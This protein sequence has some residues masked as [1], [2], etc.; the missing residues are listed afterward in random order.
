MAFEI[1]SRV[2]DYAILAKLGAGGAGFVFKAR[3]VVTGRVEALKVLQSDGDESRDMSERF[4]REIRVQASLD[5]PNIAAVYSAFRASGRLV[6]AMEFVEGR[7]LREIADLGPVDMG[8]YMDYTRQALNALEYAHAREVIHRDIKPENILITAKGQVKLTDF[9]LAKI[10]KGESHT[11]SAALM[12]S[13]RYMSPE[14]VRCEKNIDGRSDLYSLGVVLYELS[15]GQ[16]PFRQ[17]NPFDLMKAHVEVMPPPVTALNPDIPIEL[18]SA[19]LGTLRKDPAERFQSVEELRIALDRVPIGRRRSGPVTPH[20]AATGALARA[21]GRRSLRWWLAAAG[22]LVLGV[23]AAATVAFWPSPEDVV[24]LEMPLV[25]K[26]IPPPEFAYLRSPADQLPGEDEPPAR[27]PS[28]SSRRRPAATGSRP[29]KPAPMA[30]S[31]PPGAEGAAE[32]E[33]SA[34]VAPVPVKPEATVVTGEAELSASPNP[35]LKLIQTFQT[36]A[37][38][39]RVVFGPNGRLLASFGG[40][41]FE[42]WDLNS[43]SRR[44]EFGGGTDLIAALAFSPGGDKLFIGNSDGSV[45]IWDLKQQREEAVLGHSSGVTAMTLGPGGDLLIVGLSNKNLRLWRAD[46]SRGQYKRAR[47]SLRGSKQPATALAY[48]A[49]SMLVAA[50][51]SDRQL[52]VW[53]VDGGKPKRIAALPEATSLVAFGPHGTLVAA[54]APGEVNLWHVQT[55]KLVKTLPTGAQQHALSF[56]T[57]GRCFAAAASGRSLTVVDVTS[58]APVAQV[59]AASDIRTIALSQD[60]TQ[61]AA[62]DSAGAVRI[63]RMNEGAARMVALPLGVAELIALLESAPDAEDAGQPEKKGVFRRIVGAVW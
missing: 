27:V 61:V 14:Q 54:A 25:E 46:Q 15:T 9:G 18:N 49:E 4:L 58:S 10:L 21:T 39:D 62:L 23:G 17:D 3:H 36:G 29:A 32:T 24:L 59:Q 7:T 31:Q 38:S 52:L 35:G 45:R 12:G 1:G 63:W 16:R 47:K 60:A 33:P 2:G 43:G 56:V 8:T 57:G 41:G 51:T 28:R 50:A 5:H 13:L 20:E 40:A 19:I 42:V 48:N 30:G 53:N 11:Q 44:A 34:P 6:M 22:G 26:P 55:H 37:A